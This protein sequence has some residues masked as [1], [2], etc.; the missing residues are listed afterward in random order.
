MSSFALD[1]MSEAEYNDDEIN[2]AYF[3]SYRIKMWEAVLQK[4][5]D[6]VLYGGFSRQDVNNMPIIERD[7]YLELTAKRFKEQQERPD[8]VNQLLKALSGGRH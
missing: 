8:P 4:T 7:R 3:D 1:M 5:H 2:F 6:L